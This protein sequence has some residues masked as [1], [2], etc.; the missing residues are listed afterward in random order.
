M[1]KII[2]SL[3][4]RYATKKFD[5]SKKVPQADLDELLEAI[6]LAPSSFGLQPWKFVVVSDKKTKEKLREYAD[7]PQITDASH[8]IVL[9]ARKDVD[10]SLIKKYVDITAKT[11]EM[12]RDTL[13]GYEQMMTGFRK[14][15]SDEAVLEWS[16]KQVYLALGVLLT[17]AAEKKIDACPMEGFDPKG[18]DKVLG[19]DKQNLASTVLCAIGYRSKDDKYADAKKVRFDRKE[20]FTFK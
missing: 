6:R 8:L 19:L 17:S 15:M 3:T 4:W 5:S 14:S 13:N 9:C 12:P 11:R 1:N 16:K 7:Q 18:F 2:E 10:E 20:I